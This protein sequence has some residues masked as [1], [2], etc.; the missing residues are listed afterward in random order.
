MKTQQFAT[1]VDY[2]MELKS[3]KPSLGGTP[4]F[5]QIAE[6]AV[7][8]DSLGATDLQWSAVNKG[9]PSALTGRSS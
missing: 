9:N 2:Q 8:I 1:L 4:S 6:H 5:C 7:A 3:E